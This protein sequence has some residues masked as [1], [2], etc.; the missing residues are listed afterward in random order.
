MPWK[1]VTV[2]EERQRFRGDYQLNY[3]PVTELAERFSISRKTAYKTKHHFPRLFE[4]YGLPH[5]IRTLHRSPPA[6]WPGCRS[7]RCCL[8]SW[9][10]V[11]SCLS[12]G[13]LGQAGGLGQGASLG[14]R[15]SVRPE[16]R[17]DPG[18]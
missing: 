17:T 3:Y 18:W 9:V 6:P 4:T 11:P 5:R 16:R 10:S 2:S 12:P 15:G 1:G 8:S 13:L 7:S 14:S